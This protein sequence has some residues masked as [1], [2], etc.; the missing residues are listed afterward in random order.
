MIEM[1]WYLLASVIIASCA[2]SVFFWWADKREHKRV[3]ERMASK[4]RAYLERLKK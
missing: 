4:L 3:R 2:L 1:F